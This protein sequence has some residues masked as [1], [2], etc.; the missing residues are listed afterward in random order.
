MVIDN[1]P[2]N[3]EP[4]IAL[5]LH[6]APHRHLKKFSGTNLGDTSGK[7]RQSQTKLRQ[8]LSCWLTSVGRRIM[9]VRHPPKP[10]FSFSFLPPETFNFHLVIQN[11]VRAFKENMSPRRH[12]ICSFTHNHKN[13]RN[14]HLG[15]PQGCMPKGLFL[16][17]HAILSFVKCFFTFFRRRRCGLYWRGNVCA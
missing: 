7:A 5:C 3:F 11:L 6:V 17:R 16:V 12:F 10:N 2:S 8:Q 13:G 15:G 14:Y 1:M 9:V 4:W